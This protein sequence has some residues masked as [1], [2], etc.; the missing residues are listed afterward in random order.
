MISSRV[1]QCV[2]LIE[3]QSSRCMDAVGIHKV[4]GKNEVVEYTTDL[5][6]HPYESRMNEIVKAGRSE[7]PVFR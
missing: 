5:C 3:N 2:K 4:F 6:Y 7:K 1:C